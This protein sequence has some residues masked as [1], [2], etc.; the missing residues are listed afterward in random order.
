L[1]I[2]QKQNSKI[3]TSAWQSGVCLHVCKELPKTVLHL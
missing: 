1:S 3:A 2:H